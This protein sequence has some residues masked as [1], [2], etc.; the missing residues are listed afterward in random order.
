MEDRRYGIAL[1]EVEQELERV[2]AKFP[3]YNSAHETYGVLAE[4]L[5]EFFDEVRKKGHL[6]SQ[7]AMR[8]ELAQ[9]AC[10]AIR[11]MVALEDREVA[12]R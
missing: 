8:T 1:H 5:A 12:E 11:G 2:V 6:R 10:V 3:E 7:L 4:E 9:I